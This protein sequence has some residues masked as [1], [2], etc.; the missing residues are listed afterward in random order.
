MYIRDSFAFNPRPDLAVDGL[1]AIWVELLLPRTKGILICSLYR[2][3]N[4][5]SFLSKLEL[6]LS[7][8]VPGTEFYVMGDLNIDMYL[9]RSPL[10][11]KY[12]EILN[13]HGCDQL[14]TEPTRITP[15]TSS[16][17]DHIFTN[18]SEL[19]SESGVILN[20]F[21]DHLITFCSRSCTKDVFSGSNTRFVRC[22]KSYSKFSFL[23]ELRKIDWSSILTSTDVNYCLSEFNRLFR[24]AI[25]SVAPLREIRVRN[26]MNPWMNSEILSSIKKRNSLL[27]RFKKDRTNELLYKQY[28]QVRN[29]VQRD[30][31]MAKESFFKNGVER[32]RGNSG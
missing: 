8:I 27:A 6:S 28:C 13:F 25:D 32:N 1:E 16:L 3:P 5:S 7:K 21:S 23:A 10:L 24:S 4:D 12:Q 29:K 15:T 18:V 20:G 26:K 2:P 17:I 30:I 22:Y 11:A 9:S 31:K 14:I 19:V